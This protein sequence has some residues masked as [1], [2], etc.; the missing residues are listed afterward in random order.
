MEGLLGS[1]NELANPY[2]I[3]IGQLILDELKGIRKEMKEEVRR[4]ADKFQDYL[5]AIKQ[6]D[7]THQSG[8]ASPI[9]VE[10]V[11][12]YEKTVS[13]MSDVDHGQ[14]QSSEVNLTQCFHDIEIPLMP[15]Q[16][17]QSQTYEEQAQ[18]AIVDSGN[19]IDL[20]N[21]LVCGSNIAQKS[22]TS[23]DSRRG[24]SNGKRTRKSVPRKIV[25]R[26][27]DARGYTENEENGDAS[28]QVK[29]E[30]KD[31]LE[32]AGD[33]SDAWLQFVT[34]DKGVN[35][36]NLCQQSFSHKTSLRRHC[37]THT[38]EKPYKCTI[39]DESFLRLEELKL[40]KSNVHH[41]LPHN[42]EVKPFFEI[43]SV[44]T[45]SKQQLQKNLPL[46]KLC[47]ASADN[48]YGTQTVGLDEKSTKRRAGATFILPFQHRKNIKLKNGRK[49][50]HCDICFKSFV[51]TSQSYR[52]HM[53]IHT[54]ER[55]FKCDFCN[56]GFIRSANLK[57]HVRVHTGEKPYKCHL[58]TKQFRLRPALTTHLKAAHGTDGDMIHWV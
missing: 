2:A 24:Q 5:E 57:M 44:H 15:Q 52:R 46:Q 35:F 47:D 53:M 41:E 13:N 19:G 4:I 33:D 23:I 54:G 17:A 30:E 40:H 27:S 16:P 48:S 7:N 25:N 39:C 42:V 9:N 1:N 12:A 55:P 29:E 20:T 21:E 18:D 32:E 26:P 14:A 45:L 11:Q 36:C 58:C 38:G 6:N 10:E 43:S 28:N 37:R 50:Y 31:A 22:V 49:F 34:I 3:L 8:N 51:Y 56:K